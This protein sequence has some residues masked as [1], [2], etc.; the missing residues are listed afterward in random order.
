MT[1]QEL[2]LWI[3]V[4]TLILIVFFAFGKHGYMHPS[5]LNLK[6]RNKATAKEQVRSKESFAS[7][8]GGLKGVRN[9]NVLFIYKGNKFDAHEVLGLPAGVHLEVVRSTYD[10]KRKQTTDPESIAFI[11]SAYQAIRQGHLNDH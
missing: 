3:G 5:K 2:L 11:D 9:L 10:L 1:S 7:T 8:D 6:V 4:A